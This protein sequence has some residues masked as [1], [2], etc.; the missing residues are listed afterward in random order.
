MAWQKLCGLQ[1]GGNSGV[2]KEVIE[3][4]SSIEPLKT[5][6]QAAIEAG[7]SRDTINSAPVNHANP[8]RITHPKIVASESPKSAS[9]AKLFLCAFM[10][11]K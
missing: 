6:N 1:R 9:Q 11:G 4:N 7:I 8:H 10:T 5:Q 3:G 2:T